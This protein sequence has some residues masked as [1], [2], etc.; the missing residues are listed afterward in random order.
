M[1]AKERWNDQ[2]DFLLPRV[3][4]AWDRTKLRAFGVYV[5]CYITRTEQRRMAG[6]PH[7]T[8]THPHLSPYLRY[9]ERYLAV[10][11][12]VLQF[13]QATSIVAGMAA[14][15]EKLR[16]AIAFLCDFHH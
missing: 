4:G 14:G 2:G 9:L 13:Y 3:Q 7:R 10:Q 1:L 8:C 5:G 12:T 16:V 11:C 6:L 15:G